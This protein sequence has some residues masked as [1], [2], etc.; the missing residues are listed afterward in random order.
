MDKITLLS[1]AKVNLTLDVVRKLPQGY[2][3]MRSI[4]MPIQLHDTI[5][6]SKASTSKITIKTTGIPCPQGSQNAVYKAAKAFYVAT[7]IR[8]AVNILVHKRIPLASG[9]GGG[10][11][12]A[13]TVLRGLNQ[14]Y[15]DPLSQKILHKLAQKIGMDTP[16]FLNPVLSLVTHFGEKCTPIIRNNPALP[17]LKLIPQKAKKKSTARAY[18]ALDLT[19]CNKK[20]ADTTKLLKLLKNSPYSWKKSWNSLLH[21]DFSQLYSVSSTDQKPAHLTGAGPMRFQIV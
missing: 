6:L 14:L 9:L 18:A 20:K 10:S 16:F 21:N 8:P 2:H 7:K 3:E 12:N 5:T 19:L 1:V 15:G 11:S 17:R 13:A 4:M